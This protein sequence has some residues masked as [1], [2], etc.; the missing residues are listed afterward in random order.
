MKHI[1]IIGDHLSGKRTLA[2]TISHLFKKPE[3]IDYK[4]L[5]FHFAFTS[6]DKNTDLVIF[7][8]CLFENVKFFLLNEEIVVHKRGEEVFLIKPTKIFIF[9]DSLQ[10]SLKLIEHQKSLERRCIILRLS[11]FSI[12]D[13]LFKNDIHLMASFSDFVKT[14]KK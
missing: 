7:H 10:L 8:N 5:N 2:K 12:A 13:T 6:C 4:P 1:I 3:N 11:H 9:K 14:S